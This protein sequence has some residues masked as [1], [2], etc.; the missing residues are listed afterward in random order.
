MT[1][2]KRLFSSEESPA[3]C[4]QNGFKWED[5]GLCWV[6]VVVARLSHS[7]NLGWIGQTV[8]LH[9]PKDKERVF[10]KRVGMG[11]G[12]WHKLGA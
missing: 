12:D 6:T 11:F 5:S 4:R 2:A 10:G 7:R 8:P 3:L 9:L 1:M